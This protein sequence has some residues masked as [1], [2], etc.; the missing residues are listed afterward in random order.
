MNISKL[1]EILSNIN[2]K[3]ATIVSNNGKLTVYSETG[4]FKTYARME[5]DVDFPQIT[6]DVGQLL[7]AL[8]RA[9]PMESELTCTDSKLTLKAPNMHFEM[10]V[11]LGDSMTVLIIPNDDCFETIEFEELK[12]AFTKVIGAVAKE[13]SNQPQLEIVNIDGNR[14]IATDSHVMSVYDME[15]TPNTFKDARFAL[16][17]S[18]IKHLIKVGKKERTANI[19]L[20]EDV[21]YI[22]LGETLYIGRRDYHSRCN[23]DFVIK[24]SLHADYKALV[25]TDDFKRALKTLK[26]TLK[27]C[28]H[29]LN[30]SF[31]DNNT[32]LRAGDF[33]I[34]IA[35]VNDPI[36]CQVTLNANYVDVFL[37]IA[38]AVTNIF[39]KSTN[40]PVV[41]T[42]DDDNHKFIVM[43]IYGK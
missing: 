22:K 32:L 36:P 15:Q 8:K 3:E 37:K 38:N 34:E 5:S 17:S 24:E 10:D 43:P 20:T 29:Y 4:G 7:E 16:S 28:Q 31:N 42:T 23:F 27:Q 6:V 18:F 19:C 40:S 12:T 39:I 25:N 33:T 9:R 35:S 13:K 21:F 11:K 1:A 30:I 2:A 41:M 14:V 26:P